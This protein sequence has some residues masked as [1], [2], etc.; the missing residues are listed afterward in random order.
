MWPH[1]L[2]FLK[3]LA[4]DDRYR[5]PDGRNTQNTIAAKPCFMR[6]TRWQIGSQGPEACTRLLVWRLRQ[7]ARHASA[8]ERHWG[9]ILRKHPFEPTAQTTRDRIGGSGTP[10]V[11]RATWE[12]G[13]RV[14]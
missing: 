12:G 1:A 6:R 10:D 4:L 9:F 13:Y 7:T 2:V 8:I 11:Q 3:P 14:C 5:D